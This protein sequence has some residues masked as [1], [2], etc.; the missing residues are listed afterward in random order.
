MT[1][2]AAEESNGSVVVKREPGERRGFARSPEEQRSPR[3]P[4]AVASIHRAVLPEKALPAEDTPMDH[5]AK[6]HYC[7]QVA[8]INQVVK[9][10][11]IRCFGSLGTGFVGVRPD[12]GAVTPAAVAA[13]AGVPEATAAAA[14]DA[15]AAREA[16]AGGGADA[17]AGADCTSGAAASTATG[18]DGAEAARAAGQPGECLVPADA[19][20]VIFVNAPGAALQTRGGRT[21]DGYKDALDRSQRTL[22]WSAQRSDK[23]NK[24]IEAIISHCR[25]GGRVVVGVRSPS[26]RHFQLLGQVS[27]IDELQ[28]ARFLV[29]HG[30]HIIQERGTRTFHKTITVACLNI[31]LR[32]GVGLAAARYP[33][34]GEARW[35]SA[36]CYA[37]PKAL[38][39]FGELQDEGVAAFQSPARA[40]WQRERA[41]AKL[42]AK[43]EADSP[44]V[45]LKRLRCKQPVV[46]EEKTL[47]PPRVCVKA[48]IA[49]DEAPPRPGPGMT[50]VK[51]EPPEE[52]TERMSPEAFGYSMAVAS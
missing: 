9:P 16:E 44:V 7:F 23:N 36:C 14:S 17:G 42:E 2:G 28:R 21:I 1:E 3:S 20:I 19:T 51:L 38:L 45:P 43:L 13:T 37:P 39:H 46:K 29:E 5:W 32:S 15:T 50:A 31:G 49:D 24:R 33:L 8:L 30:D 35:C 40:S 25:R 52:P 27:H 4:Q 18:T 26:N 41:K 34:K 48:E 10:P 47:S 12:R 6:D 22:E 11:W